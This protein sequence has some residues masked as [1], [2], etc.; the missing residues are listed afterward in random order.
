MK[1]ECNRLQYI[2]YMNRFYEKRVSFEEKSALEKYFRKLFRKLNKYYDI[3]L[4]GYY[5]IHVYNNDFY[6]SIIT[7]EKE[8][9]EYYD[10]FEDKLDMRISVKENSNFLYK[11]EDCYPLKKGQYPIY[12]YKDEFYLELNEP[13]TLLEMGK[14]LEYSTLIYGEEANTVLT[15]GK[16]I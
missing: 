2:I 12:Q 10:Y 15:Y 4:S 16:K 1:I 6:G 14:L 3:E 7:I 13:L 8:E 11:L 9:Y 5:D